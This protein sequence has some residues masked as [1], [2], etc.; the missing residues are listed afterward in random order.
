MPGND[1]IERV[2]VMRMIRHFKNGVESGRL[3]PSL[4]NPT[5]DGKD[6]ALVV[7]D[8]LNHSVNTAAAPDPDVVK[9]TR[10]QECA[11]WSV[12]PGDHGE[13]WCDAGLGCNTH[14][15]FYCANGTKSIGGNWSE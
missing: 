3:L 15:L 9:V 8:L 4:M 6:L 13:G 12:Y 7:L 5:P 2:E 1:W 11:W 14:A 10:C